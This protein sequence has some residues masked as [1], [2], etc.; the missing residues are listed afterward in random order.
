[1]LCD[2]PNKILLTVAFNVP[3]YFMANLRRGVGTFFTFY[4]FAFVSLLTGSML[5]RTIGAMSR[6]LTQSIAPGA[7]FLMLLIIYTGFILPTPSMLPWLSWFRYINPMAY[8]FESLVINE[9]RLFIMHSTLFDST[10]F[11]ERGFSCVNPIPQGPQYLTVPN[12]YRQCPVAGAGVGS[13]VVN[14]TKYLQQNFS[15]N[16]ANKWR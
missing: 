9:V 13:M 15:Y 6:T 4:L 16:V 5:F 14:G 12:E 2:I 10:Q 3:V 7:V 8:I 11:A 1:M